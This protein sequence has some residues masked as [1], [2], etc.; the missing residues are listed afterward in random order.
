MLEW[1][2]SLHESC[3]VAGA[4]P[5]LMLSR[6]QRGVARPRALQGGTQLPLHH[7]WSPVCAGPG[8]YPASLPLST[9]PHPPLY[10]AS[11]PSLPSLTPL[12][13]QPHPTPYPASPPSLPSLTPLSTQPHPPLYP[14]SPPSL[15]S[16]T[17]SLPSLTP[18]LPS[19]IPLPTQP[20]PLPTQPHPPP[21]PASP[22]SIPSLTPS[23][24]S[25]TPLPPGYRAVLHPASTE[26]A[27]CSAPD[28]AAPGAS[29]AGV[30]V[31]TTE[32]APQLITVRPQAQ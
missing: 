12:H 32:G 9:Q 4:G 10:P 17:P 25:L 5:E 27:R 6:L 13:T 2:A 26:P 24:P 31:T 18:S 23:L 1:A 29:P 16:L 20:H 22:H 14:A 21:Y 11:P 30:G 19:L 8:P 28:T 7:S 3:E 15:P